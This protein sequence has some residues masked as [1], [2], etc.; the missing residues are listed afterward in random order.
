[1]K[2]IDEIFALADPI[3][4]I[5]LVYLLSRENNNKVYVLHIVVSYRLQMNVQWKIKE[6]IT[7]K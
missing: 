5:S 1:M 4:V 3:L 6:R 2:L 7:I